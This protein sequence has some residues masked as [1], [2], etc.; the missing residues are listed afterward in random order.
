M[1]VFYYWLGGVY[2][3][4]QIL[5]LIEVGNGLLLGWP[6]RRLSAL[7]AMAGLGFYS[8]EGLAG[9]RLVGHEGAAFK[10]FYFFYEP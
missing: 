2:L 8:F 5:P 9:G 6:R 7:L 3:G 4:V 1:A 10:V